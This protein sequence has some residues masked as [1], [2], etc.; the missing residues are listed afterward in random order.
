MIIKV[1]L[2]LATVALLLAFYG[3]VNSVYPNNGGRT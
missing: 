1:L 2:M 3:L